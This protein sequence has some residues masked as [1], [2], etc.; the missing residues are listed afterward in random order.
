EICGHGC[1]D[2][3]IQVFVHFIWR[4]DS[5]WSGF[6][7]FTPNGWVKVYKHDRILCYFH[8][9]RLSS[10]KT[11]FISNLS[12]P[13][14]F[15]FLNFSAQFWRGEAM[16]FRMICPFSSTNSTLSLMWYFSRMVLLKRR[17]FELPILMIAVSITFSCYYKVNTFQGN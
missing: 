8:S 16:G 17:P 14:S 7:N 4:K 1:K 13:F 3:R 12:S 5:T 6:F 10:S 9:S 2:N 11:S 15:I